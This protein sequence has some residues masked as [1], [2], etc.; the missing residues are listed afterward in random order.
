MCENDSNDILT[1]A[2]H[3][4]APAQNPSEE[5]L[6]QWQFKW[7]T[8]GNVLWQGQYKHQQLSTNDNLL[9]DRISSYVMFSC[10]HTALWLRSQSSGSSV[11]NHRAGLWQWWVSI[12][13][14]RCSTAPQQHNILN[15]WVSTSRFYTTQIK[16]IT[17]DNQSVSSCT[18]NSHAH[19][20]S[21][22]FH[23]QV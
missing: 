8:L 16:Q 14:E 18:E 4:T 3:I 10:S 13:A 15:T 11:T 12:Y 23:R 6:C 9:V 17:S 2:Y 7:K 22:L 1:V 20:I 19:S 21:S 5:H